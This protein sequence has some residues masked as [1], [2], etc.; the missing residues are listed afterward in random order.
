MFWCV[1]GLHKW[2]YHHKMVPYILPGNRTY[3][4]GTHFR[5]CKECDK[6]QRRTNRPISVGNEWLTIKSGN[7][8]DKLMIKF[9]KWYQ[10]MNSSIQESK[11]QPIQ[12]ENTEIKT[13]KNQ[14]R[15]IT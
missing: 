3:N 10:S 7:S 14:P 4:V 12:N 9:A 2:Q 6:E 15:K 8:F 5:C 11:N 13:Q 1:I